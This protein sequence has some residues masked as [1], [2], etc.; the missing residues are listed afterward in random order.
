M[1]NV[2]ISDQDT[3]Q[4]VPNVPAEKLASEP[5]A[6]MQL[7][8]PLCV[9]EWDETTVITS[10]D[11][12]NGAYADDLEPALQAIIDAL[13]DGYTYTGYLQCYSKD[14]PGEE[15]RLVVDADGKADTAV[16]EK[17]YPGDAGLLTSALTA[18][19]IE[20]A[21]I[22]LAEMRGNPGAELGSKQ[23]RIA[24]LVHQLWAF[25]ELVNEINEMPTDSTEPS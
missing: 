24:E 7:N 9:M 4:I 25:T 18:D 1:D 14:E 10:S 16:P 11:G 17:V 12:D 13:G 2:Y 15:W 20:C 19:D 21:L 6:S 22:T 5:F 8:E 3:I 23:I